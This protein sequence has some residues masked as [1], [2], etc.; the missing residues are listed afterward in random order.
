M[1]KLLFLFLMVIQV[2][3]YA[4]STPIG[5][6]DLTVNTITKVEVQNLY[7]MKNKHLFNGDKIVLFHMP[8]ESKDRNSF[9][10]E[11]LNMSIEKYDTELNKTINIGMGGFI[12]TVKNKNDM[13]LRVSLTTNG[14]GYID[15]DHL[16][17]YIGESDVK[18]F[19][20]VD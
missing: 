16:L 15:K 11:V 19:N 9:I 1:K 10:R 13:V 20:I 17:V 3:S 5:S 12:K 7:L 8:K 4:E 18:M 2:F 6:K 14:I